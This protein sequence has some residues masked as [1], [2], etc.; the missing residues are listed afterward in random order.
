[1]QAYL[2]NIKAKT[3]LTPD[4]FKR[5]AGEKGLVKYPELMTWLKADYGLGHGHANLIAQLVAKADQPKVP[6]DQRIDQHFSGAKAAWR[7]PYDDLLAQL[8]QF[9]G[10]VTVAPTDTYISILRGKKKFAVVAI[11]ANR[12]DLGIKLKGAPFEGRFE[13]AA[14]WN[15]MV[16][17]RVRIDNPSQLDA[18]IIDWLLQAYE[19]AG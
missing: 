3:G 2:D 11:T 16:T 12:M 6:K 15:A 4:D 19:N 5:L 10:D 8:K 7:K 13:D 14:K 1:M 9:G 18:E 17:H